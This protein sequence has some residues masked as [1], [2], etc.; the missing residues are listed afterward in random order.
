[1]TV[2]FHYNHSIDRVLKTSVHEL[3]HWLIGPHPYDSSPQYAIWGILSMSFHSGQCANA[4]ERHY[5]GW[6][7]VVDITEVNANLADYITTG[8][9]YRYHPPNG[10]TNEYYYFE[11]HQK[12]HITS[13]VNPKTYDDATINPDDLGIF[14]LHANNGYNWTD[15]IRSKTSDGQFDWEN[16]GWAPNIWEP[17]APDIPA[18]RTIAENSFG[19]NKRD[20]LSHTGGGISW[21]HVLYKGP[22]NFL[23]GAFFKGEHSIFSF[24]PSTSTVFSPWSNPNTYI[25]GNSAQSDFAMEILNESGN[26]INVHFYVNNPEDAK[27]ARTQNF[28]A[29]NQNRHPHLSWDISTEPDI[30]GYNIY[31]VLETPQGGNTI[32]N[33]FFRTGT[34]TSFTDN[35]FNIY[36][37]GL[38]QATYWVC[39]LDN[40]GKESDETKHAVFLGLRSYPSEHPGGIQAKQ[41]AGTEIPNQYSLKQNYP[42]P[43]N[44]TTT[45]RFDLPERSRVTMVIYDVLGKTIK[46]LIQ[47]TVEPGFH[48][49]RWDGKDNNGNSVSTGMYIYRI[50]AVSKESEK[51]FVQNHK[52]VLMK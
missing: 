49:I 25:F 18:F 17:S 31:R 36:M 14:V 15:N 40:Q 43:F 4:F 28:N 42:N 1:M 12:L 41:L 46:T 45:V 20:K 33:V 32:T 39:A 8:V 16:P 11:N 6:I 30:F 24:N 37:G 19:K 23:Y 29:V 10:A 44:P 21:M 47:S 3:G 7:D 48:E 52:M 13:D 5:L 26:T 50:T 38:D 9:A 34:I 27:P 35:N 22:N 2:Q 51:H